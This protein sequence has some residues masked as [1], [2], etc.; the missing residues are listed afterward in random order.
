MNASIIANNAVQETPEP[1]KRELLIK[2]EH[3]YH[4]FGQT[5]A[6]E[7]VSLSLYRDQILT[8]IGPNGAGKSTLLKILLR[9]I[10]PTKGDVTQAANLI[11]GFMPQKLYV[12]PTLPMTVRHFLELGLHKP[13]R[14]SEAKS[15]NNLITELL[16]NFEDLRLENLL[17]QPVQNVSGGEMQRILLAR[18]LLRK[19][20]LLVLDEPVQGVDI[21]TQSELYHLINQ[22]KTRLH[23]G[24]IM[25][26]HDLHIVMKTTDEVLCL[27]K[28]LCCSGHPKNV[29]SNP[30]FQKLFGNE[31]EDI[32]FY[33]HNHDPTQCSHTHGD[34]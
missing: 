32:A 7:D 10:T 34:A 3:I 30:S 22:V 2:A 16:Q 12:D 29:S 25:V 11:I 27:N 31:F 21:Q 13:L 33:E 14:R 19:P 26:S 8:L 4:R 23:C 15:V 18:A 17:D 1:N 28:H 5:W 9:L 24:I 6:L 20:D